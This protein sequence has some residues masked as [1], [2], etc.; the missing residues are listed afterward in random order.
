MRTV[1]FDRDGIVNIPPPEGGY[2]L[3]E[4]DFKMDPVFPEILRN[5]TD[6]GYAAVV[7]TNQRCIT[8]G[9]VTAETVDAI[10]EHMK[11]S[12]R[13][14]HGLTLLDV[15]F[16]PHGPDECD[17][18]KPLP[19][20]LL[21]AARR[22]AINLKESWMIGDRMTDVETGIRAGCRT[23]LVTPSPAALLQGTT[24]QPDHVCSDMKTLLQKLD[25]WMF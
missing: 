1:F 4:A 14:E 6:K 25:D 10:H 7:I 18:R 17:C 15:L 9:Y 8:R 19:G 23:I 24:V 13:E 11:R 3:S 5:V 12:L 16:C 22:H 21:T 2:V 20:M